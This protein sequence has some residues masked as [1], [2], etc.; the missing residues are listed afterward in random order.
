MEKRIFLAVLISLA[1]LWSW[2]A[3]APRLFPDSFKKPPAQ[4]STVATATTAT[5][6]SAPAPSASTST[7]TAA[8]V[9]VVSAPAVAINPAAP[10]APVAASAVAETTVETPDFIARFS[11]RGA[12]LVSFQLRNFKAKNGQ[13]VEL[14]KSR[15][16]SRTDYP[17]AIKAADSS[18]EQRANGGLY[19]LDD[20]TEGSNRV[21][22]YRYAESDLSITKTFRIDSEY[23][24]Q[25]AVAMTPAVPYR[26]EIGPGIRTLDPDEKD[27]RYTMTGNGVYQ[28]D[29]KL[30]DLNR[31]KGGDNFNVFEQA[32]YVGVE[33]NY[34]LAVMKPEK[35]GGATLRRVEMP[36]EKDKRKELY[37]GLNAT[38]E[39][40]VSGSAFFGPKVAVVLDRYGLDKTLRF[41]TFGIIARFFLEALLWINKTT[42]NYGFAII[43][44]TIV[45]KMVLYPLQHKWIVSMKKMQKIAPKMEQVKAKYKKA[46]SDP[47]Q[48]QKMNTEMMKLYQAEGINPAGGCL[49]MLVQFPIFV[50]FYNLLA[51]SIELRGAPFIL[52]IHD[53]S[54]KDPYYIL[55]LLMTIAM[56]VQQWMTPTTADAGQRRAFMIVPIVF[57]WIFK[58]FAAGLVLYWLVQNVLTI[59]Q[60][61]VMN[62]WWKE[63]P[64]SL[65]KETA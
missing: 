40:N 30:K 12:Q 44:L 23:L 4:T 28:I 10:I 24:F 16:P 63:H 1:V 11:N 60:Q 38:R 58:E 5:T 57:G 33:D 14:V 65:V 29:G 32:Q 13:L 2:A 59:V 61:M 31:E 64:E 35:S 43:V 36:T 17:F 22:E 56:F 7:A 3:I 19:V 52:W 42:K 26:V 51:H 53:L 46:R 25:F 41:G 62:K 47:E 27:S 39:G 55:P 15:E 9:S 37:A 34:F 49:P 20:R 45:I 6:A 50:G 21:L 8:P 54:A 18:I 48:R